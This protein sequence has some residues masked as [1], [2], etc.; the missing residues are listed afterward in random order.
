MQNDKSM[1]GSQENYPTNDRSMS[2]SNYDYDIDYWDNESDPPE[3][4]E[5]LEEIL[6]ALCECEVNYEG[7]IRYGDEINFAELSNT[8]VKFFV[9]NYAGRD[10]EEMRYFLECSAI[11]VNLSLPNFVKLSR[12]V[13]DAE[14]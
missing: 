8:L 5:A 6:T 11:R 12:K 3:S 10:R 13:F 9:E 7:A 4:F 1:S 2:G 14:W